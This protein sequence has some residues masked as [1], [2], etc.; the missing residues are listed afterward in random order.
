MSQIPPSKGLDLQTRMDLAMEQEVELTRDPVLGY[1]PRE[2]LAIAFEEMKRQQTDPEAEFKAST[3]AGI[4]WRELGPTNVGGR[5]RALLFDLNDTTHRTVWA[6]SVSG[7]LW[8]TTNIYAKSVHWEVIDDQF[9]NLAVTSIVQ[10]PKNHDTLYFATGEGYYNQ[11][12]VRGS[13]IFR[14]TDG[15][16]NWSRLSSTTHNAFRFVQKLVVDEYGILYAATRNYGVLRSVDH[17]NTWYAGLTTYTAT[18]SSTDNAADLELSKNGDLYAAMGI[19]ST[20]GIYKSTNKGISWSKVYS[21]AS[22]E[23]RIELACAPSDNDYVYALVEGSGSAVV[24][25]LKTTDGSSFSTV[26]NVS[27][28]NYCTSTATSDFSKGQAWYDLLITVDPNN[29]DRV[30]VGGVDMFHTTNGGSSWT[31]LSSWTGCGGIQYVHADHHIM[32]YAPGS[33]DTAVFGNDGGVYLSEDMSSSSNISNQ[34]K[35]YNTTQFYA[36]AVHPSRFSGYALA[37]SQDNGTQRFQYLSTNK[38]NTATVGDGGFCHIDQTRPDTQLT[39]YTFNNVSIST[40]GGKYFRFLDSSSDDKG[41]FINASAYDPVNAKLYSASDANK[42]K[43]WSNIGGTQSSNEQTISAMNNRKASAICVSPNVTG[44]V[45][46]GTEGGLVI[47]VARFNR[48][49]VSTNITGS[50]FPSGLVSCI[51]VQ[52][53]DEDHIL[54]TFS[55]YG[56]SSVWE[57]EDGGTTWKDVEGDLPDMPV[58]WVV[59]SPRNSDAAMVAT[60]LGIWSCDDLNATNIDWSPANGGLA[61]VRTDM[62]QVRLSDSSIIAATHGRGLFQTFHF[63]ETVR[64]DFDVSSPVVHVGDPVKFSNTSINDNSYDWDF[65]NDGNYDS[66]S[67]NPSHVYTKWGSYNVKLRINGSTGDSVVKTTVIR[68][69]PRSGTPYLASDGGN[70]ETNPGHFGGVDV[71]GGFN[72]WERGSPSN[73]FNS[74]YYNGNNAWV[75]DLDSNIGLRGQQYFGKQYKY[76]CALLSPSFNMK[77]SG[78]YRIGFRKSMRAYYCNGPYAVQVQ[79]SLDAG[80][81]WTRLGSDTSGYHWY[82]RGPS[83][84]CS[85]S[86]AAMADS[87]GF[88]NNYQNDSSSHDVSFLAGNEDVRFRVLFSVANGYNAVSYQLDGFL[89]DDFSLTGPANDPIIGGG[90]ETDL[91]SAT[92]TIS[93]GDSADLFSSR[94]KRIATIWNLDNSHNFGL[95]QVE[96]DR[97]GIGAENFAHRT[98]N[99]QKIF[100]KTIKI[101]PANNKNT[102]SVKIAMYFTKEELDAWKSA[103]GLNAKDLQLFKTTNAIASSS[104][105]D[106]VYPVSTSVDSTYQGDGVCITGTFNNGFSGVGA[107]GGAGNFGGPL[108]VSWLGFSAVRAQ[109]GVLLNWATSSEWNCDKFEIYRSNSLNG[110]YSMIGSVPG[111]G[112]RTSTSRYQYLDGLVPGSDENVCYKLKQI[113]FDGNYDWSIIRCVRSGENQTTVRIHPNPADDLVE[114]IVEPWLYNS[115][116]IEISDLNGRIWMRQ[117]NTGNSGT[118]SVK[119]LT[120]GIYTLSVWSSGYELARTKLIRN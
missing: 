23:Q 103:T 61:N 94:G 95:V 89:I 63:S 112:F 108:P 109:E 34:G 90:I 4:K 17:G 74:S 54:V 21:S 40:D 35:N 76:E 28:K 104:V 70:M 7:G 6:G 59:F 84:S 22:G 5:T 117:N 92:A 111:S 98:N 37:G 15:G 113:D 27:W 102:A 45:Y 85:V 47:K 64:A 71:S 10:H 41:S 11:D 116:Q 66:K 100:R 53:G 33:S 55:N 42:I 88:V 68:V 110:D 60:E 31:Q 20:D 50:G 69:L 67:E 75:T 38:S 114:I 87:M 24:K 80:L 97:S 44:N 56:V 62:L 83:S 25:I 99:D 16:K 30:I 19:G 107:G 105:S 39:A 86:Y 32:V 106:G 96:V 2:R 79:Y 14:T 9:E 46:I 91:A 120:S 48:F 81:S 1:V 51:C 101:T 93:A 58:R 12:A 36:C 3:F 52:K 29:R 119:D 13:G 82:N 73:F 8:K 49:P 57:T 78:T 77:K 26:N 43:R 18:S 115:Y 118:L 72:L 65:E